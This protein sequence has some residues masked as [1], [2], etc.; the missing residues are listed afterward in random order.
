MSCLPSH[1]SS[2]TSLLLLLLPSLRSEVPGS[3]NTLYI[4]DAYLG[5]FALHVTH[6]QVRTQTRLGCVFSPLKVQLIPCGGIKP[7]HR[8]YGGGGNCEE[9]KGR[10]GSRRRRRVLEGTGTATVGGLG[11]QGGGGG[12]GTCVL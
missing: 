4:N 9:D 7:P 2:T 5:I 12:W 10:L 3:T 6:E 8:K 1:V 11:S